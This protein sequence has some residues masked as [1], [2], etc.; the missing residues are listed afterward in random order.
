MP[1]TNLEGADQILHINT[2][3]NTTVNTTRCKILLC[4]ASGSLWMTCSDANPPP[5]S[6]AAT[7]LGKWL[8]LLLFLFEF[9]KKLTWE[10]LLWPRRQCCRAPKCKRTSDDYI[11]YAQ[12]LLQASTGRW[13]TYVQGLLEVWLSDSTDCFYAPVTK[14]E[15]QELTVSL[16]LLIFYRVFFSSL[17]P[18]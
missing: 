4:S 13:S 16:E 18:P 1:I 10:I 2:T 3:M 8:A 11:F 5:S 14:V 15:H 7:Y 9:N 6:W 12:G 17:V